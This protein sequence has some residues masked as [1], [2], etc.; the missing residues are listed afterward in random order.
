M[1]QRTWLLGVL[2]FAACEGP[3]PTV[4]GD[5]GG[6]VDDGLLL[7]V[8]EGVTLPNSYFLQG[9]PAPVVRTTVTLRNAGA[10]GSD[11]RLGPPR[12][13]GDEL[14]VGAF[15]GDACEAWSPPAH[16]AGGE[17]VELPL[18]LRAKTPGERTWALLLSSGDLRVPERAVQVRARVVA[19]EP[20]E[21]DLPTELVM[22][23]DPVELTLQHRG[24]GTCV[25][26][27]LE[28]QPLGS[29]AFSITQSR[30]LP[31]TV[32]LPEPLTVVVSATEPYLHGVLRITA[33]GTLV[34]EVPI[35]RVPAPSDCLA[36][37]PSVG[38]F[39]VVGQG[40]GLTRTFQIYN[41]CSTLQTVDLPL[42]GTA[43]DFAMTPS[44]P[45]GTALA[46][47]GSP[48]LFTVRYSPLEVGA[49]TAAVRITS[50]E[51]AEVLVPLDGQGTTR[52]VLYARYR[53][54]ARSKQ[55]YLFM[56]DTSPSFAGRRAVVRAR[57]EQV[58]GYVGATNCIDA[59]VAFAP[60]EGAGPVAF[61]T[62]DA[63]QLWS[64]SREPRFVENVLSAFDALPASSEI[65]ACVGPAA[66]L[67]EDAGVRAGSHI[68]GVCITD[69][70]EQS[71]QPL[72]ALSSLE[73]LADG[74]AMSWSVVA[75]S[76][77]GC[78][79][80]ALDDGVHASLIG[81]NGFRANLCDPNWNYHFERFGCA[82]G[83]FDGV[84]FL[85][86]R[87]DGPLEVR[88]DGVIAPA[89]DWAYSPA[90]NTI[91]FVPGKWPAGGQTIEVTAQLA[92]LP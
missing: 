87:P 26:S 25:V 18:E 73:A 60:A 61:T 37:A 27:E 67:L 35:R 38:S 75:P 59:R 42:V 88:V 62:N 22:A 49:D 51:G 56:V 90:D 1:L 92:C 3:S 4:T 11:L 41:Q 48:L 31:A 53:E 77:P 80:E 6:E 86:G 9:A 68:L 82:G 40:C 65:E 28:V 16:L 33:L 84:F 69:A 15:V 71:P 20:C 7:E 2:V 58:A 19:I 57:I 78:G 24:S 32:A 70:L 13:E 8:V 81:S 66:T 14:C 91:R 63:G 76:P 47:G 12:V 54:S 39:G 55:D 30:P 34:R 21:F 29:Q 85:S 23:R 36:V 79:E 17:S 89:A 74:G 10:P 5:A 72:A 52:E 64:S 46:N 45:A 83:F 50:R 44:F 43:S